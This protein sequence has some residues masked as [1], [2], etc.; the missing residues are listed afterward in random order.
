MDIIKNRIKYDFGVELICENG[1]DALFFKADNLFFKF[2]FFSNVDSSITIGQF[3]LLRYEMVKLLKNHF[4]SNAKDNRYTLSSGEEVNFTGDEE[5]LE[6]RLLTSFSGSIFNIV[7]DDSLKNNL[8]SDLTV[9]NTNREN[10]TAKIKDKLLRKITGKD[11]QNEMI[12]NELS[13]EE[14]EFFNFESA[15]PLKKSNYSLTGIYKMFSKGDPTDTKWLKYNLMSNFDF[16]YNKDSCECGHDACFFDSLKQNQLYFFKN[17]YFNSKG[18][19]DQEK[20]ERDFD[21]IWSSFSIKKKAALKF[22]F[23]EFENAT[24]LNL[25]FIMP[26]FNLSNYQYLMCYPYQPDSEEERMVREVSTLAN[27]LIKIDNQKEI[28][29]SF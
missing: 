2:V 17:N 10:I 6:I 28:I 11:S 27:Y 4:D 22:L 3:Y 16:V 14:F 5:Q 12:S 25:G 29:S 24:L 15:L 20:V 7:N 13:E 26:N 21:L 9:L 8:I 23:D 18:E 1:E 19:I